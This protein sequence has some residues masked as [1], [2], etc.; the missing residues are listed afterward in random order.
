[1]THF[2]RYLQALFLIPL[3]LFGVSAP[4][5]PEV[6][7]S[8]NS[9]PLATAFNCVNLISGQYF[10][11][12]SGV[13][14]QGPVPL[15]Y[16]CF[17][18][19]GHLDK[20]GLAWGWCM[21]IPL[22]C[23]WMEK[24]RDLKF[25]MVQEEAEGFNVSYTSIGHPGVSRVGF[26][27]NPEIFQKGYTNYNGGAITG[28]NNLHNQ[29]LVYYGWAK[30]YR[31]GTFETLTGA[32]SRRT[33]SPY[34]FDGRMQWRLEKELLPSGHEVIYEYI[35]DHKLKSIS[36]KTPSGALVLNRLD[37]SYDSGGYT[38]EASNGESVRY[39]LNV[40]K[41]KQGKTLKD[42]I[43]HLGK[44]EHS[45]GPTI[46]HG[47]STVK[48]HKQYL[49]NTSLMRPDKRDLHIFYGKSDG[50]VTELQA[51]IGVDA[52]PLTMA[53]FSYQG[54]GTT[55]TDA[56]G[57][58]TVYRFTGDQR[59]SQIERYRKEE[60]YPDWILEQFRQPAFAIIKHPL[61]STQQFFWGKDY[62]LEGNLMATALL[63][64][65]KVLSATRYVYDG[66]G[67]VT[68]ED[69]LGNLSGQGV[70][71]FTLG[72]NY[73][74]DPQV[75]CYS[76]RHEYTDNGFNMPQWDY[77]PHSG[78]QASYDYLPGTNLLTSKRLWHEDKNL[79]REFYRYDENHLLVEKIVDD[80]YTGSPEDLTGVTLRKV[81]RVVP[82]TVAPAIGH[83][84]S[85]TEYCVNVETRALELLK[86][87][88]CHYDARDLPI[89]ED[90]YDAEDCFCYSLQFQYDA[91][92]NL[93]GKVDALGQ[94]TLMA[95][96]A[97]QNKVREEL[98]GSGFVTHF[99]YDYWNRLIAVKQAHEDGLVLETSHRYDLVGN[100]IATIDA[101]GQEM[102]FVY[103]EFNREIE[104]VF[105]ACLTA[106][107]KVESRSIKKEY[108]ALDQL[109][110]TTNLEGGVTKTA[111]N[112]RGEPFFILHPDGT[113]EHFAYAL[114]GKL[115][116][117]REKN[118]LSHV[119]TYD[120]LGS[121][122]STTSYD[123][124]GVI[125]QKTT[126][127]YVGA[128]LTK[129][130]DSSGV[131]TFFRYDSAGRKIW[132]RREGG[133]CAQETTCVYDTLGRL[134]KTV[135]SLGEECVVEI[136]EYDFLDRVVLKR[137]ENGAGERL[138]QET[139][140]YDRLGN[141][142]TTRVET[143][144][145]AAS[146]TERRYDSRGALVEVTDALGNCA[147][148][149]YDHRHRNAL[150]QLVLQKT[151]VDPLGQRKESTYDVLGRVV[152][153]KTW[154]PVGNLL[155]Q[156]EFI[157][158][159]L[160]QMVRR[161]DAVIA[162][163]KGVRTQITE[164]VYEAG[165]LAALKEA[166]GTSEERI[167]RRLYNSFG[168]L[169]S[170]QLPSGTRIRHTYDGMGR[171]EF[172]S[173][174][175]ES[176]SYRYTYDSLGNLR[177]VDDLIHK[178]STTRTYDGL[179]R[180]QSETLG[181]GLTLTYERDGLGRLRTL[182]LPDKSQVAY[183]YE[184]TLLRAIRRL[185]AAGKE[186]YAHHYLTFDLLG[187]PLEMEMAG[188]LGRVTQ[189]YDAA[190]H[191]VLLSSPYHSDRIPEGGYDGAGNLL[192]R[193]MKDPAGERVL[194]YRYDA[195]YQLA[196]E[197]A[198]EH[199][200]RHD[201]LQN[202]QEKD[203][204]EYQTNSLNAL[205]QVGDT[206]FSYDLCGNLIRDRECQYTYDALGRL[207]TAEKGEARESYTYD[208]FNRRLCVIRE[209]KTPI[210]WELHDQLFPFYAEQNDIGTADEAGNLI[211]VRALGLGRGAEIG[212]AIAVEIRD[213]VYVP[214]HDLCGSVIALVDR[215]QRVVDHS[216]FSAFGEEERLCSIDNPWRFSS[217]RTDALTELVYFGRRYY[218]PLTGRWVTPDPLGLQAG[219]N[220]YAYV[221]NRP[222][223]HIDLY[224]LIAQAI[225]QYAFKTS[226]PKRVWESSINRVGHAVEWVGH[227]VVPPGLGRTV[228][229]G[230]GRSM[231]GAP[232]EGCPNCGDYPPGEITAGSFELPNVRLSAINGQ[233]TSLEQG[234]KFIEK[235]AET[236]EHKVHGIYNPT[237]GGFYDTLI[238]GGYKV[239]L[240]G[241]TLGELIAH[242]FAL[243]NDMEGCVDPKI[244]HYAHSQGG[245][246]TYEAL[247]YLPKPIR[248][249]IRVVTFGTAKIIP[250]GLSYSIKNIINT[251]DF[252]PLTDTFAYFKAWCGMDPTV[253]WIPGTELFEHG[254]D[255]PAYRGKIHELGDD[256]RRDYLLR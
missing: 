254:W 202:R 240:Y 66:R 4:T 56:L 5:A 182:T 73:A 236:H 11:H 179:N 168:E 169:E 135:R 62:Y 65:G 140:T 210:G 145:E 10:A 172:Y 130:T 233:D 132:E 83:P 154:D 162:K 61:Y 84:E 110:S 153:C 224:G 48:N 125:R 196:Y 249:C 204:E 216:R 24:S 54:L 106:E 53:R 28:Q 70:K 171:L 225:S 64:E 246:L 220:L 90:I 147:V 244:F 184:A 43:L 189:A 230:V 13:A 17:Y 201:S 103:D 223:T 173:A 242:F 40:M 174:S 20:W 116:K 152:C 23:G 86:R 207:L 150:G 77:Y 39:H 92:R 245:L 97:N 185:D 81:T 47:I 26:K 218:H 141:Q 170:I 49:K 177:V 107:G 191:P 58:Q 46:C 32:G 59:V 163:D 139:Y 98:V 87:T 188:G 148:I 127:E 248:D 15:H 113:E 200:Y 96:D 123:V 214:L 149:H 27:M 228:V 221:H 238:S 129:V 144:R 76:V 165:R 198:P 104:R 156:Q 195:L 222:L 42:K 252:I 181:N 215:E 101:Y 160:G 18:D 193:E 161:T 239:G 138:A 9:Q 124:D 157:Y 183:D 68:Q 226:L 208:S 250:R 30:D 21:N 79:V 253:E 118:G 119:Y 167:T 231:R 34:T 243:Y 74:T 29:Q 57:R 80:G 111:Y 199:H 114:D 117:K 159:G 192:K 88:V 247:K 12:D 142:R 37:F 19:S 16:D 256:F 232:Y 136:Q 180:L 33:Y 229:K 176:F 91:Q 164:C 14:V 8:P 45:S 7:I 212:A 128:H 1:M 178:T 255:R 206:R 22:R 108:N 133:T 190:Q 235:I 6:R 143:G 41:V 3:S 234:Y 25:S 67:N 72:S 89:Q 166:V 38:V 151:E 158:D 146:V 31:Y 51:P 71:T 213:Q 100:R 44:V 197:S 155:A 134:W 99:V 109:T 102:R 219:P 137:T 93:I 175:D 36:T 115:L 126:N 187:H 211:H 120:L 50:K 2:L 194:E 82:R 209:R 75:E 122:L 105:P 52:T 78:L 85:V 131:V 35:S 112:I 227:N 69:L 241:P 203:G 95:Y 55:V 186:R 237:S 121:L 205:T 60:S 217:K 94:I 63:Q 251:C